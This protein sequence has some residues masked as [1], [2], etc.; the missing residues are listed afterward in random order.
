MNAKD[1][2]RKALDDAG[3]QLR[4]VFESL[5]AAAWTDRACDDSMSGLETAEHL[6]EVYVAAKKAAIGESHE[7]GTYHS[8]SPD[9]PTMLADM[10]KLRAEAV[11]ACLDLDDVQ[12]TDIGLGYLALHDAYHV[13]QMASLRLKA[14]PEWNAYSIYPES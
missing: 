12:A 14:D 6:C 9:G 1:V 8:E 3:F 5:P 10:E 11:E 7:W 2:L 4:K 13:G